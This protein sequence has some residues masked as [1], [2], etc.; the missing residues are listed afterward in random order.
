MRSDR[1]DETGTGWRMIVASCRV[2]F[3]EVTNLPYFSLLDSSGNIPVTEYEWFIYKRSIVAKGG[4]GGP[5]ML[6]RFVEF[7]IPLTSF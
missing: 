4:S 7:L 2:T 6:T 5:K 3:L 1:P